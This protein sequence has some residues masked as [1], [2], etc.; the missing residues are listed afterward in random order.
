MVLSTKAGLKLLVQTLY[1]IPK[2]L[3][4][5]SVKNTTGFNTTGLSRFC[6]LTDTV[7]FIRNCPSK[8]TTFRKPVLLPFSGKKARNLL[9]GHGE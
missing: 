2:R 5:R 3:A 4:K 7:S 6:R 1:F 9:P 8:N